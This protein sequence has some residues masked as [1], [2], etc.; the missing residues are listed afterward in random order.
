L[1]TVVIGLGYVGLTMSAC[2][3]ANGVRTVGVEKS[4]ARLRTLR[5]GRVPFHERGLEKLV[6]EGI[7]NGFLAFSKGSEMDLDGVQ[8]VFLAVGTPKGRGGM[9]DLSQVVGA[10]GLVG[11]ALRRSTGFK[12]VVVKST[13]PPGTTEGVIRPL[14]ER[15][16][17]GG[18]CE[19]GLAFNPEFLREGN[20]VADTQAPDRI[21]IG[22]KDSAAKK[23]LISFY[24]RIYGRKMPEVLLTNPVNA[25]IVKYANNA[26][27]ATKVSF[28][29]EVASLC[30]KVPDADVD[31]VS[32]GLGMD[33]RVGRAYLQAGLGYG[34]SCLPKDVKGLISF[35]RER[36]TPL[37][38]VEAAH[39]ANSVQYRRALT[40]AR[41]MTGGL[42]GRRV[43]ILGVAFKPET[44]DV[45]ESISLRLIEG[46]LD[47]GCEV[48]VYDPAALQRAS[49]ALGDTV[50]YAA[51][52]ESC[53]HGADL[54]IIATAWDEF[55]RLTPA[56]F[57]VMKRKAVIDGRRVFDPR[58]FVG[59]MDFA[60][61][62]LGLQREP[63]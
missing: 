39:A 61:V 40:T 8:M 9:A 23:A 15:H 30:E 42:K 3:A 58:H 35:A 11:R 47:S 20:A 44:D 7:E 53:L 48:V 31:V 52:V 56:D 28:V 41:K 25:E 37:G 46:L 38:V 18:K 21:V 36:G 26:F 16:S 33:E 12:V 49:E 5:H 34:G 54:C 24:K 55:R 50:E 27:L 57:E 13:V 32:A 10:C 59:S 17:L 43:A 51:S 2:L 22:S 4:G 29:N 60:A 62:G 45:R 63:D 1:R 14:L 19:F 6:R